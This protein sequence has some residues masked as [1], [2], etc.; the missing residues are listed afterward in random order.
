VTK[1]AYLVLEDGS[2]YE[3]EPFGAETEAYGE[4]VF[5][6]SMTGYQEALTDPSF[7]GQIAVLTYPLVGNYGISLESIESRRIQVAGFV[8]RQECAR[9]SH[10]GSLTS[11]HEYLKSEGVPGISGVDTRAIT[12][13]LRNHGVMMGVLCHEAPEGAITRHSAE[14]TYGEQDFVKKVTADESYN[15]SPAVEIERNHSRFLMTTSHP[16]GRSTSSHLDTSRARYRI[17]ATDYGLKYN[18]SRLLHARGCEVSVV[19]ATASAEEILAR[20]PDGVLLSPGPGDPRQL[21]YAVKMVSG[22]V[23]KL[24]VFGICLGHQ[25]VAMAF[26]GEIFKLKFGHRGANHPVKDLITGRVHI[27]AQNHGYAVDADTLPAELEVSHVNLNDATV[28]GLRHR[29]LPI[30]TIQYHSEASPGPKDNEY[31]FDRFLELVESSS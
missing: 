31:M 29:E 26:G 23:G 8:V 10:G 21:D 16:Q 12:R 28:E 9:P 22:L 24:P 30:M 11:I 6:T 5:F 4:V 17:V 27:T 2:V 13:R 14:P 7:A 19:P 3:G 25:A 18:I 15:Y 20:E 1:K